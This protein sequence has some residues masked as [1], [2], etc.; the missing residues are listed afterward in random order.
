M[1]NKSLQNYHCT[2]NERNAE[3][4]LQKDNEYAPGFY[5][6]EYIVIVV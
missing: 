1:V 2:G 3:D 5:I 6:Y 4:C